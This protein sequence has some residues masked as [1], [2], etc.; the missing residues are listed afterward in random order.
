MK[1]GMNRAGCAAPLAAA[2]CTAIFLIAF[3]S[4]WS[5]VIVLLA[6]VALGFGAWVIQGE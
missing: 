3:C 4:N 2:G 1:P 5:I 6:I